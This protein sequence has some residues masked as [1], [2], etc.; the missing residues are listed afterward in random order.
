MSPLSATSPTSMTRS[1]PARW[2]P[3]YRRPDR[4]AT[5]DYL[6]DLEALCVLP[7]TNQPRATEYIGDDRHDPDPDRQGP[8][9][10]RRRWQRA[11]PR[12]PCRLRTAL[13][14]SGRYHRRGARRGQPAKRDPSDF[15]L[16]KPQKPDE[17]DHATFD[18]PWP[19]SAGLAHRMFSRPR[20]FWA[21]PRHPRRGQRPDLPP[22]RERNR[23]EPLRQRTAY[24]PHPAAQRHADGRGQKMSKSLG[25]FFTVRDLLG[26]GHRARPCGCRCFP[27]TTRR[28]T[29]PRPS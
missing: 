26:Q 3:S 25:N 6:D 2:R 10:P 19:G 8:R 23:P 27:G 13:P 11:V 4:R 28:W 24:G 7:V 17:P 18:S 14:Q 16:W 9:L 12:R 5:Q 1:S 22:P 15:V 20:P 29:S 21:R